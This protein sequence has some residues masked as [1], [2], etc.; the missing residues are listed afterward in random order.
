MSLELSQDRLVR[1]EVALGTLRDLEPPKTH[2]GLSLCP[3]L[4]V[5]SD[6]VIFDYMKPLTEGL[7]P[8]RAEDSEAELAQKD[9][10]FGGTGRASI[11]DWAVKDHYTASDVTRYRESLLLQAQLGVNGLNDLPVTLRSNITEFDQKLARDEA[12]RRRKMD[13]RVEWLIMT[14]LETGGIS[15]NDGRIK[16]AVDYGRPA[17][18][19][20]EA[21]QNGLWSL[22]TSDPI[23]DLLWVQEFMYDLYGVRMTRALTSRKVLNN[24]LNSDK[25][26]ARSGLAIPG[27][28]VPSGGTVGSPGGTEIDPMYLIDGWGAGAARAIIERQTGI[29]FMEPYDAVYRTRAVGSTTVVNNRFMSENKVLLLPDPEDVAALDDAIG[30]GRT[31]TSPHPEGN[32]T[33]GFY[34]WER[35]TVDPWGMDRGTGVKAFPV[36]PHM[37]LTYS[38]TVLP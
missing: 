31:L 2:I 12:T 34:E 30:F 37:E 28:G 25:F 7:A 20:D 18:Q 6:D 21:P 19:T 23:R 32:W 15:Y 8:A 24:L 26:A 17:N 35:S 29:Q 13:N 27:Y 3:W 14:A 38:L 5:A 16:F 9:H 4:E 11:I 36:F 10:L 22:T 33:P 1:K